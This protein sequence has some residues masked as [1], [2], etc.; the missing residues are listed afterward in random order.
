MTF[1]DLLPRPLSRIP[2][3]APRR[4][5]NP[6]ACLFVDVPPRQKVRQTAQD[7]RQPTKRGYDDETPIKRENNAPAAKRGRPA[8]QKR[9]APHVYGRNSQARVRDYLSRALADGET[10]IGATT[11]SNA[12]GVPKET[13]LKQLHK[14]HDS[15]VIALGARTYLGYHV[16]LA[17]SDPSD[18]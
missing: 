14:L 12:V 15:G 4:V 10:V 11:I 7:A 1:L 3:D 8:K 16:A 6:P 9:V 17:Q 18:V 2:A 13:V 5:E